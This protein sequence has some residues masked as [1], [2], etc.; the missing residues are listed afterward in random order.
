MYD[1]LSSFS[2]QDDI[3]TVTRAKFASLKMD[4]LENYIQLLKDGKPH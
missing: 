1:A 4:L 3:R 2:N